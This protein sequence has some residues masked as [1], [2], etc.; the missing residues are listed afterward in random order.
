MGGWAISGSTLSYNVEKRSIFDLC[1]NDIILH[2]VNREI[3]GESPDEILNPALYKG[4]VPIYLLQ[5]HY[6]QTK[7]YQT[8]SV[9]IYTE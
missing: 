4:A 3:I 6:L 8:R 9:P 1:Q 5:Y 7:F 2:F